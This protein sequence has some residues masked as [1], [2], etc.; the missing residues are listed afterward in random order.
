MDVA[1]AIRSRRSIKT[2]D[3][4][5]VIDDATLEEIF[6]LVT[7]AP[8]SFNLQHWRFVVVRDPQ[9]REKLRAA[10]F[11][12][13]HVG[14]ASAVVVVAARLDAHE[15]AAR[16]QGHVP[17]DEQRAALVK[18]IQGFYAGKPQFQRDEA[19][20]SASLAAMTLMLVAQAK[21]LAT[22]PMI[23]FDPAAVTRIVALPDG[24]FPVMLVVLGKPGKGEPFPTSR[25]PLPEVVNLETTDGLGLG[26]PK[27]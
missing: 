17:D 24:C 23:G 20:R 12:Q 26:A 2:F 5:H 21:G 10:S 8:S 13:R 22:C 27:P 6:L 18:T 1:E 7:R 3:P 25:L 11:G 9:R 15:D 4:D 16:V 19:I 14:E